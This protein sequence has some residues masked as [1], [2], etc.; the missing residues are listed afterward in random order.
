MCKDIIMDKELIN[1]YKAEFDLLL[2]DKSIL[3]KFTNGGHRVASLNDFQFRPAREVAYFVI[4]DEYSEFR[5]AL[6]EG[7][8][9]E[10]QVQHT[11]NGCSYPSPNENLKDSGWVIDTSGKFT[12]EPRLYQIK[13]EPEFKVGDWLRTLPGKEHR[14]PAP[15]FRVESCLTRFNVDAVELWVPQPSEWCWFWTTKEKKFPQLGQLLSSTKITPYYAKTAECMS[16]C[17]YVCCEPFLG[18]LPTHLQE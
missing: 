4:D 3:V 9:I 1:K 15:I 2:Q 10:S 5:K 7:K 11:H 6:A 12:G 14:A 16:G 8:T 18:P 13:P 17:S